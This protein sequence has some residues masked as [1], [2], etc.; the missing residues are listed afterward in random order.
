MLTWK[1]ARETV[2]SGSKDNLR[3][4]MSAVIDPL[5]QDGADRLK[6]LGPFPRPNNLGPHRKTLI[7]RLV[8]Q[9]EQ[10]EMGHA[11]GITVKN[12]ARIRT[13]YAD[14]VAPVKAR[15]I[16]DLKRLETEY[17]K[18]C[19]EVEAAYTEAMVSFDA[20]LKNDMD[21]VDLLIP[22]VKRVLKE[23][24]PEATKLVESGVDRV[25]ADALALGEGT[26][27]AA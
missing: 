26:R 22:A 5:M 10:I 18:R 8:S 14:K 1:E 21:T 23:I 17:N 11:H 27:K 24:R 4:R 6:E 3:Q 12:K 25:I 15:R 19:A 13:Q 16:E 9:Y 7:K 2:L 20:E